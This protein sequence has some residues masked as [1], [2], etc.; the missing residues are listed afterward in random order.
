MSAS[1]FAPMR[2][3]P[4]GQFKVGMWTPVYVDV[5]TGSGAADRQP[6][7]YLEIESADSEGV[8]TFYRVPVTLKPNETRTFVGYTK[9]GNF[10]TA[11]KVGVTLHWNGKTSWKRRRSRGGPLDDLGAHLY[12]SLGSRDPRLARS[13]GELGSTS[14]MRLSA[15][16]SYGDTAPR[17]AAFE[18]A[19]R[20]LARTLVRLP[21]R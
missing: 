10:E 4:A 7:A 9:P 12:L 6:A 2:T 3:M 8:G 14:P 20:A 5:S 11:A 19:C 1:A 15:E 16:S 18:T 21:K 13:A 17:Y